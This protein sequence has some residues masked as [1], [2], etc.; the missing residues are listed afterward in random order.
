M[1]S[2]ISGL[3]FRKI[4]LVMVWRQDCGRR[5]QQDREKPLGSDVKNDEDIGSEDREINGDKATGITVRQYLEKDRR[6]DISG[7]T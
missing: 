6:G 2:C 3:H 7:D 4:V 5:G 1:G